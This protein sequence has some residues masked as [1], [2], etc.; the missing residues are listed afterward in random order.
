MKIGVV[1]LAATALV[2]GL[3]VGLTQKNRVSNQSSSSAMA[4]TA[5]GYRMSDCVEV[6]IEVD[7]YAGKSGKSSKSSKSESESS[8]VTSCCG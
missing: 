4:A 6:E 1:A 7:A 2:I 5:T 3:S 8:S